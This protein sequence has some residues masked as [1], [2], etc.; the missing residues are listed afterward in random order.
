MVI[1]NFNVMRTI[2]TPAET[3]TPLLIDSNAELALAVS[4][5]GLEPV[6]WQMH[7]RFKG[8]CSIKDAQSFFRLPAKGLK[9][10][11]LFPLM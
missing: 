11:D 2:L 1:D 5:Q 10:V 6:A 8:V 9:N 3:E 4:A 7:Q